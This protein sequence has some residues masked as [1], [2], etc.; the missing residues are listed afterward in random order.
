METVETP[1]P[2]QPAEFKSTSWT[3]IILVAVLGLG[4]LAC[5]AHAGCRVYQHY[6]LKRAPDSWCSSAKSVGECLER[7]CI[8]ADVALSNDPQ[9]RDSPWCVPPEK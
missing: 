1:Q 4:L 2:V 3:K 5:S 8:F 6:Q 7:G 9:V